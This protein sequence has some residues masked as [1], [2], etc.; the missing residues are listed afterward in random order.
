MQVCKCYQ[1]MQVCG[2]SAS[3]QLSKVNEGKKACKHTS[4]KVSKYENMQVCM[5]ASM[6]VFKCT[7]MKVCQCASRQV[8]KYASIQ[9][10]AILHGGKYAIFEIT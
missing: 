10:Y 3:M 4:M 7:S 6:K 5:Y 2:Y 9:L 1:N 8:S